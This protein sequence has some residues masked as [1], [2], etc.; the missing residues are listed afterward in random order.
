[1][2]DFNCENGR[3]ERPQKP[4]KPEHEVAKRRG[5]GFGLFDPFFDDFFRYPSLSHEFRNMENIMKTDVEEK[6]NGYM[7][8]I[9]MPGFNKNDINLDLNNGYLTIEAKKTDVDNEK[10]KKGNYIRRERYYGSCSRSFYVGDISENDI[11]AKLD[12]G[13]LTIFVP[14]EKKAETKK[15]IEIK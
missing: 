15:R 9:E 7:L 2:K 1:M 12:S 5:D 10:D 13:I 8:E 3:C 14:K 6:E 4:N 11:N